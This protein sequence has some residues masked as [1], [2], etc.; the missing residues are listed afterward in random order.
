MRVSEMTLICMVIILLG[1]ILQVQPTLADD[2][3]TDQFKAQIK[4]KIGTRYLFHAVL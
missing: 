4:G 3:T 1:F 2:M